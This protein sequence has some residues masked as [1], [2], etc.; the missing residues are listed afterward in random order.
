[1]LPVTLRWPVSGALV[2][3][4]GSRPAVGRS[5]CPLIVRQDAL[6]FHVPRT[7]PPQAV[8]SGQVPV[9]PAPDELPLAPPDDP[10][11]PV[12]PPTEPPVPPFAPTL[13]PMP[14]PAPPPV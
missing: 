1:M 2:Q 12:A 10:P 3:L 5:S 6:T 9:D 8:T 7:F 14:V 11:P 4:R 13:P